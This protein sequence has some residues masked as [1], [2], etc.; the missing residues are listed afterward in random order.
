MQLERTKIY[1]E[2]LP[3][4]GSPVSPLLLDLNERPVLLAKLLAA[5]CFAGAVGET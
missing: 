2:L 3:R 1:R 5:D 4:V